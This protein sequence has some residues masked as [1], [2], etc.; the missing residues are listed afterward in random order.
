[1][2]TLIKAGYLL[3]VVLMMFIFVACDGSSKSEG[4][5][6]SDVAAGSQADLVAEKEEP[7]DN[8][9]NGESNVIQ[10]TNQGVN[11]PDGYPLDFVP[12]MD[13]AIS[14]SGMETLGNFN[15]SYGTPSS[16]EQVMEFY[17]AHFQ[18]YG[19]AVIVADNNREIN[20]EADGRAAKILLDTTGTTTYVRISIQHAQTETKGDVNNSTEN[21]QEDGSEVT[22]EFPTDIVPIIEGAEIMEQSSEEEENGTEY[23]ITFSVAKSFK[24][25]VGFYNK[26]INGMSDSNITEDD[27]EFYARAVQENTSVVIQITDNGGDSSLVVI[28]IFPE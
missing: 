3:M 17:K 19:D 27:V 16:G 10:E 12:I 9:K 22:K 8:D 14:G 4:N 1:M 25:V 6:S 11:L 2:K 15:L 18:K 7:E 26:V 23:S 21:N 20:L 5:K 24:E 13:D 28:N